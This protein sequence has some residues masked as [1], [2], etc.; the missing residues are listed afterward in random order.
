M[1]VIKNINNSTEVTI[2]CPLVKVDLIK[3]EVWGVVTAEVPDK[4][5]EIC[6]YE[7]TAPY[8]EDVVKEMS[9][10]TDG[11]NIFPLRAM[12]GLIA[13]GKGIAIEFRKEAK[14][15]YMGFKVVDDAEWNK[16][17]ENVYT[18]FS[19][20]GRYVK[21]WKDGNFMRYTADPGEVSLVDMPCLTR[22]HFEVVKADG[23]VELRKFSKRE[24]IPTAPGLVNTRP[25]SVENVKETTCNCDCTACKANN[26]AGCT[27]AG[28]QCSEGKP[29]K[30]GNSKMKF[31]VTT[32]TGEQ[33]LPY[34]D[35]K[36]VPDYKLLQQSWDALN[37]GKRVAKYTGPDKNKAIRKIKQ[38]YA[39]HDVETPSEKMERITPLV[40]D[41]LE[42]RIQSRAY[43]Q[44]GKGMYTVGR[45][46]QIV[47]ELGY[48]WMS[49]EYERVDEDD[50][51]EATDEVK[52][53]LGNLLDALLSYTEE[54]VAEAKLVLAG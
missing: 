38:V 23:T 29:A 28:C 54:Q 12:H 40:K 52:S 36:D 47:D 34:A 11:K 13:A 21:R 44:L 26:C 42:E 16:V 51:S 9:K 17:Q 50:V 19:Q 20:G 45:F 2:F 25:T 5:E 35:E 3:R 48:L 10:A 7:T 31:L 22:A 4:T 27:M 8:Y 41:I 1:E 49:L 46:A 32:S 37:E 39:K 33:Y 24:E 15:I 14:E 6:D 53:I 18:G 30:A 43:G